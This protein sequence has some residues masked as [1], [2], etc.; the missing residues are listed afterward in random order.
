MTIEELQEAESEMV[1]FVQH[2]NFAIE[3]ADI[4]A[5]ANSDATENVP[6]RALKPFSPIYKL[7]PTLKNSVLCV[8]GRL[9]KN[10]ERVYVCSI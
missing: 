6:S 7:D 8:G 1:K 9:R 10:K 2:Q 3:I 4:R 5:M